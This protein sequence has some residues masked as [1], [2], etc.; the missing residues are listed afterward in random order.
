MKGVLDVICSAA[1][2]VL[3]ICLLTGSKLPAAKA[4]ACALAAAAA[5]GMLR[6]SASLD[7][8]G[9]SAAKGL[10][11][12][13]TIFIVI[14]PAIFIYELL[15]KAEMF[16][17]IRRRVEVHIHSRLLQVLFIGWAFSSFLQSITGFGVPVAVTAPI[18]VSLG[19]DPVRAV[20][21]G[22]LGHAWG[23]TFGTLALAWNSLF[24]QVPEAETAANLLFYTCVL[25]WV[26]NFVC[27]LLILLLYRGRALRPQDFGI[28]ALLSLLQGGGQLI[29]ARVSVSTAC[30]MASVLSMGGILVIDH[31]HK[32]AKTEPIHNS[33]SV[34]DA[35]FPFMIL[36]AFV[37]LCLFIQP[38]Y[39][40]LS[41][42]RI[43]LP[44]PDGAGGW[45]AYSPICIFTHS[46][47]L[48][49]VSS[50]FSLLF[51]RCRGYLDGARI[52]SALQGVQKKASNAILPI[53]LL[54][55]MS[56]VM[57]ST[58]QILVL[59]NAI[60]G[61]LSP[62]YPA[63]A[64]LVGVLGSFVS[65]SN[66]S[67]NILFARFQYRAAQ[68]IGA[69]PSALLAAQTAGGSVGNLVATSNVVLGL[70]TVGAPEKVGEV[71]HMMLPIA[72]GCGM[73]LGLLTF[74]LC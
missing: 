42:Y 68:V 46:G 41:Q 20:I 55:I 15:L 22:I 28:I 69:D 16:E 33:G 70:S 23:G 34:F 49:L 8:L 65:S 44:I 73:F 32:P 58:G 38:V 61:F 66:M 71:L 11:N 19:L 5:S 37:V 10:W 50:L 14:A 25:L 35:L 29:F 47:T 53:L 24:L 17:V 31:L 52:R 64:P 1:P 45:T 27:G 30:F 51:Y 12:A 72:L 18:L 57:D 6:F 62:V 13:F 7:V 74:S 26:Y 59:A 9:W 56:K 43:G 21:I 4:A 3:L 60:A 39:Q 40:V 2:I 48:L 36:T 67:S 63:A 54:L